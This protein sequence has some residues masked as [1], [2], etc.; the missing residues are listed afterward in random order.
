MRERFHADTPTRSFVLKINGV[1]TFDEWT[2]AE[3]VR[4]LKDFSGS[5]S[6]S[7]RDASRSISTFD[8]ASPPAVFR[9]RPGPEVEIY[10]DGKLELVGYID[11]VTPTVE[12]DYAEISIS[13]RD[14]AGDLVDSAAAPDGPGE[15]TDVKL[16]A[17]A[18]KIAKP[19]GLSVKNEINTGNPFP[20]YAFGISETAFSAIEKG[21]RAR[22]ALVMSDGIGGIKITRTGASLAPADLTLPGNMLGSSATFSHEGRF[23]ETIVKG[24]SEKARGERKDRKATHTASDAPKAPA[25]RTASDG[26]ATERERKG[27]TITGRARDSE[28]KRHRPIVHMAKSQP[29]KTSADDEAD[30]RMRTARSEAEELTTSV[31]GYGANGKPW[32]VNQ[33]TM[34]K[35]QFQGIFRQLV[36]SNTSKRYD[37]AGRITELT[38]NSPEAFDKG[39]VGSRRNNLKA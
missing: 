25:D 12:E 11:K 38:L 37:D 30:W 23:S 28:I 15:L 39:P 9:L 10:I 14:K 4:D 18:N 21:A 8:Y 7:L 34:V 20:R 36:I 19:F 17:A 6:F 24:Q 31:W 5:F 2:M 16:E 27:A 3:V 22:H 26:S 32:K 33:L 35:D 1:G 13:G 29:D